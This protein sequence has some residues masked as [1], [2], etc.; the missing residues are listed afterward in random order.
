ML[1][2]YN[3][4]VM[5]E[6]SE[7]VCWRAGIDYSTAKCEGV[8]SPVC[9][10]QVPLPFYP[11]LF[12]PSKEIS[13]YLSTVLQCHAS[14][15]FKSFHFFNKYR[16]F[17]YQVEDFFDISCPNFRLPTV[18]MTLGMELLFLNVFNEVILNLAF[19]VLKVHFI[20]I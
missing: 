10:H 3:R 1:H 9:V 7:C 2:V 19:I 6:K 5:C 11:I 15:T 13:V 18:I 8:A 17:L 14:S 20:V 16:L 12:H 4:T